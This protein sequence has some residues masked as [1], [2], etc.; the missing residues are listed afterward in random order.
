MDVETLAEI[1]EARIADGE[2]GRMDRRPSL[3]AQRTSFLP[4]R[5]YDSAMGYCWKLRGVAS[6]RSMSLARSLA[7]RSCQTDQL[8]DLLK[9]ELQ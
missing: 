5:R 1:A 4:R 3:L 9:E 2:Q 8:D 7:M 6:V